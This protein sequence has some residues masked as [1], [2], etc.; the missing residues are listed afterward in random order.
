[1]LPPFD[2]GDWLLHELTQHNVKV[3]KTMFPM[4]SREVV[5][6]ALDP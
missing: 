3:N 4:E 2:S 6:A 5:F 1:M